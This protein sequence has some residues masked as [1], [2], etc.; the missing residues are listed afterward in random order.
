[1][2]KVNL[3]STKLKKAASLDLPKEFS[4]PANAVLVAQAVHV[5]RDRSHAGNSRVLTRGEV[6]LTTAKWFKQKGTGR[7][8]HGAQSAPIFVGG[9]VA[10]GPKG[11]KKI[12]VLPKKMKR[13]ALVSAI[14]MKLK[15]NMVVGAKDLSVIKKTKEVEEL[16]GQIRAG[17]KDN[18]RAKTTFVISEKNIGVT[19]YM[20]NIERVN[21]ERFQ[22]LNAYKVF[23]GG[24]IVFDAD[25]FDK[26]TKA[27]K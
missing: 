26:P 8:R 17:E 25:V 18:G 10:H 1:M 24:R 6:S 7:A 5:Y 23:L 22:D 9:G 20:K 21:I 4:A 12:L 11:V 16:I 14:S 3:Y 19:V 13:A 27:K 15:D 2:A